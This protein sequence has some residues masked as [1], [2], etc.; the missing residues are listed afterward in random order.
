MKLSDEL[1][2]KL[3]NKTD[4]I[5]VMESINLCMIEKTIN[6]KL[7]EMLSDDIKVTFNYRSSSIFIESKTDPK[8]SRSI[9]RMINN[10]YSFSIAVSRDIILHFFNWCDIIDKLNKDDL[11]KVL[12]LMKDAFKEENDGS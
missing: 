10:N 6:V 11:Q 2:T 8:W 3:T 4:F 12:P 9:Y 1:I 5:T 7:K